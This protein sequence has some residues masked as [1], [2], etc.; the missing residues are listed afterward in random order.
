M[1]LIKQWKLFLMDIN[2][3]EVQ[4]ANEVEQ[5]QQ[6]L[7]RKIRKQSI[8]YTELSNIVEKYGY[9]IDIHKKEDWYK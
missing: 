2:K 8:R 4:V 7:N 1:D 5:T 3:T 6:V 9:P